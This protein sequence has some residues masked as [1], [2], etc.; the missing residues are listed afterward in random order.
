MKIKNKNEDSDDEKQN[1]NQ[2]DDE[3]MIR[4]KSKGKHDVENKGF[5]MWEHL[6]VGRSEERSTGLDVDVATAMRR[7]ART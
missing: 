6:F 1:E 3:I 4:M 5:W 7:N 2:N